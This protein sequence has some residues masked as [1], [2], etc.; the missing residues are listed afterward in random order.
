[1]ERATWRPVRRDE[2]LTDTA[3]R[4]RTGVALLSQRNVLFQMATAAVEEKG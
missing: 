2:K 1:M 4:R 3:L